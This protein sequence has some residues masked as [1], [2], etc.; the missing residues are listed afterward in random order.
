V[1]EKTSVVV[2]GAGPAGLAVGACLRKAGVDFIILEK[3]Q[4]VGSSWRRHYERLHLHTVK[5]YSSLPYLPLPKNYPR[6]AP[7]KLVVEYLDNYA[8]AF[9]LQPRFG[10]TVR[11]VRR[12]GSEWLVESTS[13]S[14]RSPCV[15][16]AS[17]Y[18]AEPVTPSF[19]GIETFKGVVIHARDYTN[20]KP[21][22]GQSVL[23][24]G[25]GNTGAEIAL[26]LAEQGARPTI[27]VRGGVH[28]VPRELFGIPMQMISLLSRYLPGGGNSPLMLRLIDRVLGDLSKHG[29]KR[30]P[31]PIAQTRGGRSRIPVIDVGTAKK[32]QENVI[33]IAPDITA[34]TADSVVFADGRKIGFDAIIFATGYRAN[35]PDFVQT[36]DM[37]AALGKEPVNEASRRSGLYFIGLRTS[38]AGLLRDI[39]KEATLIVDDIARRQHPVARAS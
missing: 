3:E 37:A 35:Y 38:L 39:S 26:D 36:D 27:S 31:G 16:I 28:I 12:D 18:N 8:K 4:Q 19:P 11:S 17:G 32:I 10:E 7:R 29:I 13:L 1:T 6:Y 5:K 21:F 34:V 15:V 2:V 22:V 25:M 14:A 23:V 30:P 20:A 33:K 9:A 24:I